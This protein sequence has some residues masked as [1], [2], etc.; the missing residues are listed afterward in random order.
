VAIDDMPANL[1]VVELSMHG[2][3]R[4]VE[5]NSNTIALAL[6]DRGGAA[7]PPMM[8]PMVPAM[9]AAMPP[10][11]PPATAP[12]TGMLIGGEQRVALDPKA[13]RAPDC[14]AAPSS[15]KSVSGWLALLG[16]VALSRVRRKYLISTT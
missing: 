13:K 12:V 16:L 7:S 2:S 4:V 10:P 11:E 15:T 1:K 5:D 9:A 6:L 8:A 3:G 14:T